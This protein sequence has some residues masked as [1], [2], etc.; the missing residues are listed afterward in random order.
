MIQ[1]KKNIL[2]FV[3]P[4]N[5]TIYKGNDLLTMSYFDNVNNELLKKI[6]K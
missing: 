2:Y 4:R 1:N 3:I 5:I 6:K